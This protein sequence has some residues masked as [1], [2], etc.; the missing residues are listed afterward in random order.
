LGGGVVDA[1]LKRWKTPL[2]FGRAMLGTFLGA[3]L[4]LKATID[5]ESETR[6]GQFDR[7]AGHSKSVVMAC[8]P[9][10]LR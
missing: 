10:W 7:S 1:Y 5:F 8:C 4:G 3:K 6:F 2:Q 9:I